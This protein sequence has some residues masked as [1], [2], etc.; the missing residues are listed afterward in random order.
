[1]LRNHLFK[2]GLI[3][4][5]AALWAYSPIDAEPTLEI[6]EQGRNSSSKLRQPSNLVRAAEGLQKRANIY[7]N[8]NQTKQEIETRLEIS[9]IYIRLG[10]YNFA[11]EQLERILT[12][13][14]SKSEL[15][16]AQKILGNAYSG[17]GKH[18]QA[19][20]YYKSSLKKTSTRSQLS[21]LNNLIWVLN[22]RIESQ[23][24]LAREVRI[25]SEAR[26]HQ[27]QARRDRALALK[28][29]KR[30]LALSQSETSLSAVRALIDWNR[31]WQQELSPEYLDRGRRILEKLPPSRSLVYLTINWAKIDFSN[32]ISWLEKAERIAKMIADE[33]AKSYVF[34]EMGYYYQD[35]Q[36]LEKALDYA[37]KAQFKAQLSSTYD[38]LYRSQ[39]L[40]GKLY[41]QIGNKNA[42]IVA[43]R[44]ALASID[45][46]YQSALAT[47]SRQITVTEFEREIEPVYRE[48]LELIL[49]NSPSDRTTLNEA[50]V[51]YDKL[52]LAQLRSYFGD[53]C[54]E[55][56][57]EDFSSQTLLKDK[58][59][60]LINS[61]ILDNEVFI[62]LQLSDGRILKSSK[63]ISTEKLEK[64]ANQWNKDLSDSS[65]WDFRSGSSFFYELIV[66]PFE[67]E[68][69][70]V[71]PQVL[72]FIHDG[73]L[74]NLPMAALYDG[75]RFLA[76]KW[77]SVSSLGLSF[78][79][80]AKKREDFEALIFGLEDSPPGWSRLDNVEQEAT[81]VQNLLGGNK[82]LNSQFTVDS[83]TNQIE[84]NDEYSVLHL[85][86]HG[87]FGGTSET[88]FILAYDR[89]ISAAKLEDILLKSDRVIE[90]LVL[91]ACETAVGNDR[92]LLGLAGIAARSG[93]ASTL[94]SLWQVRDDEQSEAVEAFYTLIKVNNVNKAIALQQVQVE[95][96]KNLA[97]PKQWAALNLI[98]DW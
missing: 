41:R 30:A 70:Q 38:S 88:S 66:K 14:P 97:H 77:A 21:I 54:F 47:Q 27:A 84:E 79:S 72:V 83:L 50:L 62:I 60:V 82:F 52:R 78:T 40:T 55:V 69:A 35:T 19:I 31:Q 96:I 43:Y 76:E 94:G 46:V 20:E 29:T 5:I 8:L 17:L 34:L 74:R 39:S 53:N 90:L 49:K 18:E 22:N 56:N 24:A 13:S 75:E 15:A 4:V 61:I 92:A 81:F 48:T 63:K 37:K 64:L 28:Y 73:I 95:K 32:R 86:T 36:Y 12:L 6:P 58:N 1:M 3:S 10:Q 85:A 67:A 57:R 89:K 33:R 2:L 45:T 59:A 93:V 44:G 7:S 80:T 42:A 87:Y 98:G 91:S 25:E 26:K 9:R 65:N 51:V 23:L 16:V 71:N 11:L 68:L